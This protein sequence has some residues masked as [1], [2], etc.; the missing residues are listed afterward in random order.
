[1]E[2]CRSDLYLPVEVEGH[3]DNIP[4]STGCGFPSNWEL[5]A[6]RSA[7]VVR[8]LIEQGLDPNIFTAVGYA[9]TRPLAPNTSALGR[10]MNRR[11]EINLITG[12]DKEA[13]LK[14]QKAKEG[15]EKLE[16]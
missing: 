4:P 11:I 15:V 12:T 7:S 16:Q 13:Y 5:S 8:F 9:D 3:T 2:T 14:E 1:M 10:S 6:A